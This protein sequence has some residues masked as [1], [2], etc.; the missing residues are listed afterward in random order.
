MLGSWT[1]NINMTW[2]S[3]GNE[4]AL[5]FLDA[6]ETASHQGLWCLWSSQQ[7][8]RSKWEDTTYTKHSN[9]DA[10]STLWDLLFWSGNI[11]KLKCH[12]NQDRVKQR[13]KAPGSCTNSYLLKISRVNGL[14][15]RIT[16]FSLCCS[17]FLFPM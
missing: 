9:L 15:I 10:S 6:T 3:D 4:N 13:E 8:M 5:S 16:L 11:G 12:Q 2:K 1:N 14:A 7:I 17:W